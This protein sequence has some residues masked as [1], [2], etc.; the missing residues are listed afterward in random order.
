LHEVI[1]APHSGAARR[2][3]LHGKRARQEKSK[4][5]RG[6]RLEGGILANRTLSGKT[7]APIS[8]T[9]F[10]ESVCEVAGQFAHSTDCKN[11]HAN[12]RALDSPLR[13]HFASWFTVLSQNLSRFHPGG[14]IHAGIV[15]TASPSVI[16]RRRFIASAGHESVVHP[17]IDIGRDVLHRSV[18]E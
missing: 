10:V 14:L 9:P 18:A 11:Q 4:A 5:G 2:E 15:H 16:G 12:V 7:C 6:W 1:L 3:Y 17:R 8:P 13:P